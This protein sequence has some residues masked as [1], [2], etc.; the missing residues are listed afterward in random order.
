MR[1]GLYGLPCAGKSFLLKQ[2][3]DIKV[4]EGSLTM[5]KMFPD[6][7]NMEE[8][9]RIDVRVK[10]A[11][12]LH[13]EDDFIMDGH[14]AFGEKVVF[15]KEDGRLYDVFL[16]LYIEPKIL[17]ERMYASKKN[18]KYA[19]LNI[20]DWQKFEIEQLR[21]YCHEH[22][23][24]FFVIDNSSLGYFED[25]NE[26]IAFIEAVHKGYSC[27]KFAKTCADIILQKEVKSEKIILTDGDKTITVKDTSQMFYHY[28]TNIFDNNFYTGYQM[29]RHHKKDEEN[30][31]RKKKEI[32]FS[33]IEKIEWND[34]VTEK[35]DKHSY[36]LTSGDGVIWSQI[37]QKWNVDCFY[38]NQMSADTKYFIAKF[39]HQA[40][41]YIV[42]YGDSMNDYYML[43]EA[44]EGYLAGK[45]DGSVSRSLQNVD[46]GGIYIV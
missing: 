24:D 25:V 5:K 6:F 17:C 2:V 32:S 23:K 42:A 1:L 38:G 21:K 28:K 39:L 29:W 45:A 4:I 7:D 22:E 34:F 40:G 8:K 9:D 27:I 14:Y 37:A 41:K 11:E 30:S 44:E 31:I 19:Q 3:K 20:E 15:T 36:I 35:L 33:E 26:A 46:L 12:W 18:R 10:F 43:Q 13:S 16:Y